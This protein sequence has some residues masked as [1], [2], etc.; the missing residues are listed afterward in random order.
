MWQGNIFHSV[1]AD[2]ISLFRQRKSLLSS[3]S[4][5]SLKDRVEKEW[6]FSESKNFRNNPHLIGK[7]GGLALFEH[8]YDIDIEGKN[9]KVILESL[10]VLINRFI[11]WAEQTDLEKIVQNAKR[12]WI[13]PEIFS[14][15]A[16]GFIINDVKVIVKVDLAFLTLDNKFKI[17]DWKTGGFSSNPL[18]RNS[19]AEFQ[20]SVYQLWPHLSLEYP[21]ESIE[22]HLV[23]FGSEAIKHETFQMDMEQKEYALS[24]IRSSI[25]NVLRFSSHD[26]KLKF[27]LEDF[28]F[29]S[30][31]RVCQQC[32]FKKLC[33]KLT[34][35]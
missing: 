20:L 24:L 25:A 8:E 27:S 30:S 10:E 16:P 7:D 1:V 18:G 19:Q 4:F 21:L 28:D 2:F 12:I 9:S 14:A 22:A 32:K 6:A 34:E 3:M 11:T 23:Y 15:D 29:A 17:F 31:A 35:V 13:E 33:Q 5:S 26:D